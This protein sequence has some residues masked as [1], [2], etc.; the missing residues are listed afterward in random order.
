MGRVGT[1]YSVDAS[2][3]SQRHVSPDVCQK[4]SLEA[5]LGAVLLLFCSNR[6]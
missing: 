6:F 3:K 5:R 4:G 2:V 1:N